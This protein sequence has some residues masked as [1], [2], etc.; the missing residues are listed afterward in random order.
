MLCGPG[1]ADDCMGGA[2]MEPGPIGAP[3]K[4]PPIDGAVG[5]GALYGVGGMVFG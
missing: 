2:P 1:P 4:S 5:G 3:K